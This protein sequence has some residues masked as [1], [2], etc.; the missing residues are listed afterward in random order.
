[1]HT[2]RSRIESLHLI[3]KA[4]WQELERAAQEREHGWRVMTLATLEGQEAQA[5]SVVLREVEAAARKVT[6][7]TDDRSP[8]IAQLAQQPRGTLLVWCPRLSWQLRM[9]VHL[10]QERDPAHLQARWQRL[11][12]TPAAQDYLS[13]LAPGEPLGREADERGSREHFAIIHAQV[14]CADWLELH[15]QGHRRAQFGADGPRWVQP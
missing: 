3:E 12:M 9:K 10:R 8:K 6:F 15:A 1:M 5:R 13:P 2:G 4:F 14:L 11:R 7:Y